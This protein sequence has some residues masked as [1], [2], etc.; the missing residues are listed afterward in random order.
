MH[1]VLR[2]IIRKRLMMQYFTYK[3][4]SIKTKLKGIKGALA[5]YSAFFLDF[6]SSC[7]IMMASH[8]ENDY[9]EET[10][11]AVYFINIL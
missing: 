8:S 11:V 6:P 9:K 7:S 4:I 1:H 2:M 5:H 10:N 3:D